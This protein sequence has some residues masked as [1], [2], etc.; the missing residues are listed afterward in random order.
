[1]GTTY[2]TWV[3]RLVVDKEIRIEKGDNAINIEGLEGL[4]DGLY[5]VLMK[6]DG[7]VYAS[8]KVIKME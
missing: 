3:G 6:K 7:G 5:V 4:A 1:L 8:R 2:P